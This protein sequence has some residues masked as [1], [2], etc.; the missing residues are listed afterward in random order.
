MLEHVK[1]HSTTSSFKL[2]QKQKI[3]LFIVKYPFFSKIGE[4]LFL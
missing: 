3:H 4:K 2:T 1:F